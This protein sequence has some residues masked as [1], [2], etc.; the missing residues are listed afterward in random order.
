M[1]IV[2]SIQTLGNS[3]GKIALK[4]ISPAEK[5]VQLFRMNL[6]ERGCEDLRGDRLLDEGGCVTFSDSSTRINC[7]LHSVDVFRDHMRLVVDNLHVN[8]LRDNL[9]DGSPVTR[10]PPNVTAAPVPP[11]NQHC[12][13]LTPYSQPTAR[14]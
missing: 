5:W 6:P 3:L 4:Y 9:R 12:R 1:P 13:T 7:D 11:Q 10:L 8:V 2:V 14:A